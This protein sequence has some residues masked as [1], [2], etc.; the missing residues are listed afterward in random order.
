MFM[1]NN[2]YVAGS[3]QQNSTMGNSSAWGIVNNLLVVRSETVASCTAS[4][5]NGVVW[6]VDIVE[7]R[8]SS[9]EY[10]DYQCSTEKILCSSGFLQQNAANPSRFYLLCPYFLATEK[11]AIKYVVSKINE[12]GDCSAQS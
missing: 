4:N 10:H 5:P 3:Q 9:D 11:D 7:S 1:E 2:F 12:L 8:C 6:V